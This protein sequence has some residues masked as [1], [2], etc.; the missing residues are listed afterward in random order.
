MSWRPRN[1]SSC[2]GHCRWCGQKLRRPHHVEYGESSSAPPI[3]CDSCDSRRFESDGDIGGIPVWKCKSCGS[4]EQYGRQVRKRTKRVPA[5]DKPG[6]G[7]GHFCGLQC[8][9]QFAVAFVNTG[10]RLP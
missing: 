8:S 3:E 6:D 1:P 5:Y 10:A 7:D 4:D 9:Y 2:D